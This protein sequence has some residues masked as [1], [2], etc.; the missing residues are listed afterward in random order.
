M[1]K[2]V[3]VFGIGDGSQNKKDVS[4]TVV[5]YLRNRNKNNINNLE[6]LD[7]I[8]CEKNILECIESTEQLIVIDVDHTHGRH[9]PVHVY[10]GFE[11][12][13]FLK[14]RKNNDAHDTVLREALSSALRKGKLPR[15]RALVGIRAVMTDNNPVMDAENNYA[16]NRAC[17]KVFEIT[18]YWKI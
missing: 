6:L 8:S 11:M 9:E 12:D 7:S 18:E 2:K 4:V 5:E 13:A 14:H 3:L 1:K 10:E 16:I 17:Q 15:H